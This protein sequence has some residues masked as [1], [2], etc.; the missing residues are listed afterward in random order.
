VGTFRSPEGRRGWLIGSLRLE[1]L[2]LTPHGAFVSGVVTGHLHSDAGGVVAVASRPVTTAADVLHA[3]G[4]TTARVRPFELDMIG[5][6][7]HV[8]AFSLEPTLGIADD[9]GDR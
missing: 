9:G 7:V 5:I 4:R 2:L 3:E 6:P 8:A 1:R